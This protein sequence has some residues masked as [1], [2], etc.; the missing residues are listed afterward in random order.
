MTI[1]ALIDL[2]LAARETLK[3][4]RHEGVRWDKILHKKTTRI[5]TVKYSLVNGLLPNIPE[6]VLA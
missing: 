4:A 6:Y 2:S 1:I 3:W 5:V